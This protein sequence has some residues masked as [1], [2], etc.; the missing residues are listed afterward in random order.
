MNVAPTANCQRSV[1]TLNLNQFS[2]F[3]VYKREFV[4][5]SKLNDLHY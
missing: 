5:I 2:K 1:E 4:Y 3:E